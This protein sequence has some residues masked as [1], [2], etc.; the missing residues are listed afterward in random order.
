ML[1]GAYLNI[2]KEIEEIEKVLNF[3]LDIDTKGEEVIGRM[4]A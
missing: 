2:N 3:I 1:D 4:S